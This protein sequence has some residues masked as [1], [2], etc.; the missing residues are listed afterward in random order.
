MDRQQATG[1]DFGVS[2]RGLQRAMAEQCL[3]GSEIRTGRQ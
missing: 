1:I 2:L 3:E